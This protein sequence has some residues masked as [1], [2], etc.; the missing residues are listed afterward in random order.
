MRVTVIAVLLLL[1]LQAVPSFAATETTP[2]IPSQVILTIIPPK[3]PTNGSYPAAVVSLEDAGSLPTAALSNITVFLTSDQTNIVSVPSSVVIP[4]GQDYVIA[5]VTTTSTPGDAMITAS[6]EGLQSPPPTSVSTVIPSGY[7]SKLEVFTSPS[8]FLPRADSGIV[9]VEVVDQAGLPSKAISAIPVSL[10]SS[11]DSIALLGQSSLTI[12][13]G[14][15]YADGSFATTNPG[16][17][18]ISATST[19]Y[20]T[21][22]GVVTVNKPSSCTGSCGAAKLALRVIAGRTPGALPADGLLYKVLEVSLETNGGSPAVTSSVTV[23]ELTSDNSKLVSVPSLVTIPSGSISTLATVGTSALSG[24]A[25]ITATA[26]GLLP[27]SMPIETI[28]PAPSKLQ[29]YVAP[30]SI[31]YSNNGNYPILVVQLQDSAGNPARARQPTSVIVTSSNSSLVGSFVTL[32]IPKGNDY[33]FSYLHTKGVGKTT[34]TASSSDLASSQAPLV[35]SISPLFVNLAL[36][37]PST[38]FI[39][40]NQTATFTFSA[41]LVG[42]P[43]KGLNISWATTGGQISP[44]FGTTGT[45]GS[46]SVVFTPGTYGAYNITAGTDSPQTGVVNLVYHLIVAEVPPKPSPSLAEQILGLWYY[47][48]AAAAV[49]VIAVVYL[50][51]MRRKKQRAEIEAG[52]E[53]V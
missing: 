49:V 42:Q 16:T 35:S 47:L 14:S 3:L 5:N 2:S 26:A 7:P 44:T 21:G 53:V 9:R 11:N 52:F 18:V 22:A 12:P 50:L 17:A 15:I 43:L 48:V 39:Y 25:N 46:S 36:T 51:R 33:V 8:V 6:S 45:S 1:A 31:A 38:S 32:G 28:V 30:S 37:S 27:A 29:A 10:S 13:A 4:A 41:T 20:T 24:T 23:V 34:L 40:E 19:G